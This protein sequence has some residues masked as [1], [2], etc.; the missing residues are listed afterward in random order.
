MNRRE[1][2]Q[3]EKVYLADRWA[4]VDKQYDQMLTKRQVLRL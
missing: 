3:I 4:E 2:K 1:D